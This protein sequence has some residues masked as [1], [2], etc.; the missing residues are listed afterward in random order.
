LPKLPSRLWPWLLLAG[1][2]AAG[3]LCAAVAYLVAAE[4]TSALYLS[5]PVAAAAFLAGGSRAMRPAARRIAETRR[6]GE[7][8]P[9]SPRLF[10][11]AVPPVS[12][13]W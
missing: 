8:P 5:L 1:G 9:T 7:A 11:R 6:R 13:N 4:I 10:V 2:A 3:V 12:R